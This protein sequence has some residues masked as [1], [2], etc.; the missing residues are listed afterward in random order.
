[1]SSMAPIQLMFGRRWARL[2][3]AFR[4]VVLLLL[5]VHHAWMAC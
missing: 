3:L 2:L 5:A 4:Y 1:M